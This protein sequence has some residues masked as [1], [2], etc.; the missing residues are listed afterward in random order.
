MKCRGT[1]FT[2]PFAFA[3]VLKFSIRAFS[4]MSVAQTSDAD[5]VLLPRPHS[6]QN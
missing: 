4:K 3:E 1:Q 6:H 5:G 2:I